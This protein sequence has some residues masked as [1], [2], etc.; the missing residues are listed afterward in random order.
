V[1]RVNSTSFLSQAT[2][3]PA[4]RVTRSIQIPMSLS[5]ATASCGS[6]AELHVFKCKGGR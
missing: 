2:D 4:L 6:H 3:M 5:A 1:K